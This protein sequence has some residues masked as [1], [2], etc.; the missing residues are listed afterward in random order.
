MKNTP[1]SLAEISTPVQSP[2]P[3]LQALLPR[4]SSIGAGSNTRPVFDDPE[5]VQEYL[6]KHE[7]EPEKFHVVPVWAINHKDLTSSEIVNWSYRRWLN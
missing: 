7:D 5:E 3:A 1:E 4:L 2:H 6:H